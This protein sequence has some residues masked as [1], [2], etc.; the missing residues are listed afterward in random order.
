MF[1]SDPLLVLGNW[2]TFAPGETLEHSQVWSRMLLWCV[3]GRGEVWVNGEKQ[4]F[5][6]DDYL[7]LP[8][9]HRVVYQADTL[10]PLRVGGIHL[11]PHHA[12]GETLIYSAV[13]LWECRAE[14]L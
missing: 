6:A 13:L 11:I 4:I 1:Q 2:Y 14:K 9:R 12:S 7:L 5:E 3:Q 10:E 8:W